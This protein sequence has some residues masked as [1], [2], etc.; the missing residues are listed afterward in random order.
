[1]KFIRVSLKET[2]ELPFWGLNICEEIRK[3]GKYEA[4]KQNNISD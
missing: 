4:N 3:N 2:L 1:M